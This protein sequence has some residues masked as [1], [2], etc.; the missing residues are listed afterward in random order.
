MFLKLC[1]NSK[2]CHGRV[3][4][5]ENGKSEWQKQKSYFPRAEASYHKGVKEWLFSVACFRFFDVP[6]STVGIFGRLGTKLNDKYQQVTFYMC[7]KT[8]HSVILPI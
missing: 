7:Q 8:L 2:L 1:M 6:K 3:N 4:L 5:L